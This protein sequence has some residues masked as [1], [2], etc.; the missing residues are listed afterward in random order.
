MG[1]PGLPNSAIPSRSGLLTPTS[2][3][4]AEGAATVVAVPADPPPRVRPGDEFELLAELAER[5]S[6]ELPPGEVH[7]GDDA[8]VLMPRPGKL[9]FATDVAVEGVHFDLRI[10]SPADAGWKV[11]VANVSDIAAMGGRPSHVVAGVAGPGRAELAEAL[12]GL[13]A[14]AAEYEV[15]LVG[16]DLSFAER[17]FLSVAILGDAGS[18]EPV[19]RSGARVGDELWCTGRLGAAAAGLAQLRADA[20]AEGAAVEAFRRPSARVA[21]GQLAAALGASAMIDVSDGL[22]QDVAHI[23]EESGVGI[24]LESV[25]V[26]EGASEAQALGGGEDYELVFAL[27]PGRDVAAAFTAAGLAGPLRIGRCVAGRELSLLGKAIEATG[28]VHDLG[29]H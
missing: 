20:R 6:G 3:G 1:S 26:A 13:L 22:A 29:G 24:A 19:L 18:H 5:L 17:L 15:R 8:A 28:Y 25:P 27:A 7:I 9:L 11:L 10:G 4:E 14:A 2:G 12:D 23:G 21:E 16:G